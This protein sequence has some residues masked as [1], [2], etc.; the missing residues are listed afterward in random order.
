MIMEIF[1][2]EKAYD[3]LISPLM[4]QIIAICKERKIS[5]L[6]SFLYESSEDEESKATTYMNFKD[7]DR[8]SDSLHRAFVE[9]RTSG[10]QAMAISITTPI[11]TG[12]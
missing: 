2:E 9:C 6:A 3:D 10:I 5:F 7:E 12:D 1:T 4:K 8:F 11:S